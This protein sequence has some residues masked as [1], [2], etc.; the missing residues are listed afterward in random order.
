MARSADVGSFELLLDT[1]TNAFGGILFIA[2]LVVILLQLSGKREL[3]KPTTE[4]D[5]VAHS[6]MERQIAQLA[7]RREELR[8]ALELQ[9]RIIQDF[10][11]DDSRDVLEQL[12][13]SRVQ[14]E[15]MA[16]QR[17][18]LLNDVQ[19]ERLQIGKVVKESSLLDQELAN[20]NR[21]LAGL[22]STQQREIESRT[23]TANMP[24]A[25]GTSK[26]E[27]L[28]IARYGRLYVP[29][30]TV[31]DRISRQTNSADMAAIREDDSEVAFT[32]KPYAGLP[33]ASMNSLRSE[34]ARRLSAYD[35]NRYYLCVA[36]WNDS[37]ET[38]EP[39]K[40]TLIALGYEYRLILML[41]GQGVSEGA[42]KDV[43]V[44]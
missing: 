13:K 3:A 24:M 10:A 42:V 15:E 44:Q 18:K 31:P 32:P 43:L 40:E 35:A 22:K 5:E 29:F 12:N 7:G 16:T 30:L 8:R 27:A 14:R 33:L 23:R 1:I 2:I 19:N 11:P 41:D 21:D 36:I 39:L 6:R 26:S 37:F 9:G 20:A 17:D 28:V 25:R 4:L 34:L 38:F